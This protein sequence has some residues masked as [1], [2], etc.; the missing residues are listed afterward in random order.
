[1]SRRKFLQAAA[2]VSLTPYQAKEQHVILLGDSVFDN[3]RYTA[4][5]PSV[6]TQVR[7]RLAPGWKASLLAVDGATTESALNQLDRLPVDAGHLVLSAGGNDALMRKGI[8]DAPVRSSADAFTQLSKGV[9]EFE[10]SY[11]KLV[12]ACLRKERPLMLCTIYNGNFPDLGYQRRVNVALA[13]FNDA[14]VRTATEFR[15]KV[16]ELRQICS[17][18]EDYAN[19][20]EPSS[21]GGEK[22]AAAIVRELSTPVARN[23]GAVIVGG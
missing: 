10:A 14:I 17:K 2:L 1:M 7:E 16:L 11:R 23:V 9:L 12:T 8:L 3:G 6:I 5:G 20:I 19:A 18:P 15:L 4:G 13:A 22:I 21:I